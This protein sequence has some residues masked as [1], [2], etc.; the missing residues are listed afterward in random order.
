MP[1]MV[2]GSVLRVAVAV[3][4]AVA[5]PGVAPPSLFS[6]ADRCPVSEILVNPCR[7]WL[8]AVVDH[9]PDL[10]TWRDQVLAHEQRIGR[11]VDVVHQY[12]QSHQV[13]L[14]DDERYFAA[15]GTIVYLNW[16]PAEVWAD[17]GGDVPAVNAQI[18]QMAA[19]IKSLGD[20]KIILA[21]FGEPERYVTPGTSSCPGLKGSAGSPADY[22]AMWA[23]VQ[24]RFAAAGTDNVVWAMNYLGYDGWDCLFPELWPGNDRVDWILWD[25]YVGPR[26]TW[27][28]E[29]GY[30]YD[31][32]EA[33][34]DAEH[35][36]LSKAWG[37]A[38][39]GFWYGT[40]D[41]TD[42]YRMYD[43]AKAALHAGTYPRLKLYE[44]YDTVSAGIDV[45]TSYTAAGLFDQVEQD[46]YTAFANDPLL[47]D[48]PRLTA[49]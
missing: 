13:A 30:F 21:L 6:T 38:E 42:A 12:H 27:D 34:S 15:R 4:A 29:I 17:A 23:N 24:E 14:S 19:S 46:H 45:R 37:L 10:P 43:D 47:T 41:Q 22:L 1:V 48:R 40:E 35:D 11:Q 49:R 32:L 25:P 39:Y 2:A 5:G 8:G 3:A 26:Q 7:P 28:G 9:Y 36:Y 44:V 18:D 20:T 16:R 33:K 31:A